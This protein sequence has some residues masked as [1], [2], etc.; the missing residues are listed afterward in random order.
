[1]K[2]RLLEKSENLPWTKQALVYLTGPECSLLA[3]L[4][5]NYEA[6]ISPEGA[7]CFKP[8]DDDRVPMADQL[9]DIL[10]SLAGKLGEP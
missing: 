2:A 7:R 6:L 4:C 10:W 3:V 5:D 1:M 8:F 9:S